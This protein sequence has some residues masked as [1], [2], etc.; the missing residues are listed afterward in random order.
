MDQIIEHAKAH[1]LKVT[2]DVL[3]MRVS[4]KLGIYYIA[5]SGYGRFWADLI[6]K[7]EWSADPNSPRMQPV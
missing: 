5:G 2:L 7:P 3:T 6:G 4:W 1:A